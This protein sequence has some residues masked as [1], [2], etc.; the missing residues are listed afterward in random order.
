MKLESMNVFDLVKTDFH[1]S[2]VL[3]S[4]KVTFSENCMRSEDQFHS[5]HRSE[6]RLSEKVNFHQT[7][8]RLN[9]EIVETL[10]IW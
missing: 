6:L 1:L 5:T 8:F 3:L 2:D 4:D 7:K 10:L 9:E